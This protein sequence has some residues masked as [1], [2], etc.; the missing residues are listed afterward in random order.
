MKTPTVTFTRTSFAHSGVCKEPLFQKWLN[1]YVKYTQQAAS[2]FTAKNKEIRNLLQ[3]WSTLCPHSP[4]GRGTACWQENL[5]L[6]IV[7]SSQKIGHGCLHKLQ[8]K[9]KKE[10]Y[11]VSPCYNHLRHPHSE[12]SLSH[13]E[14]VMAICASSSSSMSS[15][16]WQLFSRSS[17]SMM[18]IHL[19]VQDAN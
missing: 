10:L 18:C 16:S 17:F 4:P 15:E 13:K 3:C 11:S 6:Q 2:S 5:P 12:V 14:H 19:S 9:E 8:E 7:S 1:Y